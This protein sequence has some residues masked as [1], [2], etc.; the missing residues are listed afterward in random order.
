MSVA[1]LGITGATGFIGYFVRTHAALRPG[2]RC[3]LCQDEWFEDSHAMD[4]FVQQCDSILH[5]AA[6]NRTDGDPED[7]YRTNM[8]LVYTLRDALQRNPGPNHI[9]FSSSTQESRDNPYGR[10]KREG[11]RVLQDWAKSAGARCSLLTI[12]NVFG[13]FCRPFYN[14]V[15]ATFCHQL[16]HGEQPRIDIDAEIPL[17]YVVDLAESILNAVQQTH[18]RDGLVEFRPE[19]R[20]VSWLLRE[21]QSFSAAYLDEG[22]VPSFASPFDTALFNTFRSYIPSDRR[23]FEPPMRSDARGYLVE[24]LKSLSGGQIF[25]SRTLPGVTRGNHFHTRKVERFCVVEGQASIRLRRTGTATCDE[26]HVTGSRPVFIDMPVY[27]TH[28]IENTGSSALLTLFWSNE[29]YNPDDADTHI[30][31]VVQEPQ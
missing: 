17:I 19:R 2:L 10:S 25:F 15:V 24:I 30:D 29:I 31:P 9:L 22:R 11:G 26:Y 6:M 3:V 23:R 4:A 28:S 7:I 16:V 21:L 20:S 14:S 1:T 27:Y 12:P 18:E 8:R 13:P 5:L